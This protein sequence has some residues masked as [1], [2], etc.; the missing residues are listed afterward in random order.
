MEHLLYDFFADCWP[1]M[2]CYLAIA[3]VGVAGSFF[4]LRGVLE[5]KER[6]KAAR[7]LLPLVFLVPVL[8]GGLFEFIP[9]A[10]FA[11]EGSTGGCQQVQG[12][13]QNMQLHDDYT[14]P[15]ITNPSFTVNGVE[16][17]ELYNWFPLSTL[18][19][20]QD[21]Q[22]VIIYYGYCDGQLAI[23]RIYTVQ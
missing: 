8:C 22:Q 13:I 18:E 15:E 7:Q 16:F 9:M 11:L 2:L 20:L 17:Q 5:C 1:G 19:A 3:C 23:W 10:Q 12:S 21:G 6:K 14:D 4:V